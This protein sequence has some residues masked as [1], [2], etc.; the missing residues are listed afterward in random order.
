M[1]SI[2]LYLVDGS[3]VKLEFPDE[4]EATAAFQ[5]LIRREGELEAAGWTGTPDGLVNLTAIVKFTAD[6]F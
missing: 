1:P 5:R 6:G 4:G 2:T 3:T